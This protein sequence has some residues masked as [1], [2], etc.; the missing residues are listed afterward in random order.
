MT[1]QH[2]LTGAGT[3]FGEKTADFVNQW[4]IKSWG[5]EKHG[6]KNHAKAVKADQ[7]PCQKAL[8]QLCRRQLP[9]AGRR[10]GARLRAVHQPVRDLLQLFQ[11]CSPSR[12]QGTVCRD[13]AAKPTDTKYITA[14][15]TAHRI[16]RKRCNPPHIGLHHFRY[17]LLPYHH[18]TFAPAFFLLK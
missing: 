15:K 2:C 7:H 4:I 17:F 10:R 11:K 9:S 8:L 6:Y 5:G 16:K 3:A 14:P 18:R 13:H 1:L 12:R